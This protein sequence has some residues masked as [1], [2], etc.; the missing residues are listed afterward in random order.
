[1]ERQRALFISKKENLKYLDGKF[2]RLYFGDEF[3]E[4]LMPGGEDVKEVMQQA[5]SREVGFTLVTPYVTESGLEQLEKLFPL[6][7]SGTEVVIN[8]WGVLRVIR[9]GF[10]ELVP[11]L[12]RLLTKIKR[13]PRIMN[14]IDQLP[15]P[16]LEHLR[17]TN[18]GVPLYQKFLFDNNISRVELD[19]PFQGLDLSDVQENMKLSLYMPYAYVTTTRICLVANCDI[20]EKKGFIGVFP[21]HRE[22]Q[23]YTFYLENK[24]MTTP[25]I[26]RGNTLFYKNTTVPEELLN[27]SNIDRFIISPEIPH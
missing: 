8:D 2:S 5:Q 6:L 21:C 3:C 10:P 14:F 11:V 26:R 27:C 24:V 20:P 23:K 16:A 15:A 25:L 4:R 7:P 17:K 1:M 18:L 22:C 9:N 19:N 13:G 12:G